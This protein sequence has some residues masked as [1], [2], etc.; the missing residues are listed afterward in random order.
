[1]WDI[2]KGWDINTILLLLILMMM[3]GEYS[4][5]YYQKA[6]WGTKWGMKIIAPMVYYLSGVLAI[7]LVL[8]LVLHIIAGLLVK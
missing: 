8:L 6:N 2:L 7:G 1:M 5:R 3:F 4:Q